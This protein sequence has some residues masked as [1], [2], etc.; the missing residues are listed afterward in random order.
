MAN[1]LTNTQVLLNA[2]IKQEHEENPQYL[3]EDVF[4]N[5]SQLHKY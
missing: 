1:G 3:R 2:Y 4:L 5:F